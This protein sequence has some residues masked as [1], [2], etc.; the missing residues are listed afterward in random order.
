MH[1]R[2]LPPPAVTTIADVCRG[3]YLC[4]SSQCAFWQSSTTSYLLYVFHRSPTHASISV[5]LHLTK[6][7]SQ[8]LRVLVSKHA[9]QS[10][11]ILLKEQRWVTPKFL[12]F[13]SVTHPL[14]CA[15]LHG[16][17]GPLCRTPAPA[18][19]PK[20]T[21]SDPVNGREILCLVSLHTEKHGFSIR[22]VNE[23]VTTTS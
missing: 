4:L 1:A 7:D 10:M 13:V 3:N 23:N 17:S 15:V 18:R 5:Y 8:K 16:L 20:C 19:T 21:R 2:V 6:M 9:K 12:P 11:Q 14:V 22:V